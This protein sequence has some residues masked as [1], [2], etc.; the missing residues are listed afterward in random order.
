MQILAI[1]IQ[2]L[3]TKPGNGYTEQVPEQDKQHNTYTAIENIGAGRLQ[4]QTPVSYRTST[5]DNVSDVGGP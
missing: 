4:R 3:S 5:A 2:S 1:D